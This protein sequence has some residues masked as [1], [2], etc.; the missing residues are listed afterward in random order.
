[1]KILGG[2]RLGAG[3]RPI[4]KHVHYRVP[5]IEHTIIDAIVKSRGITLEKLFLDHIR[6]TISQLNSPP[7]LTEKK[8]T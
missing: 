8:K 5:I 6:T 2:A 1:M 7:V 4:Y 3:R